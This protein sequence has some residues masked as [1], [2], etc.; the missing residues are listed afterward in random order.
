MKKWLIK[1]FLSFQGKNGIEEIEF[2]KAYISYFYPLEYF[3]P[4]RCCILLNGLVFDESIKIAKRAYFFIKNLNG[5][6]QN[7][8]L[9]SN[10]TK[11]ILKNFLENGYFGEGGTCVPGIFNNCFV[12]WTKLEKN[13]E[14]EFL[15]LENGR[16]KI[17]KVNCDFLTI[18]DE[19]FIAEVP[20][21]ID[22]WS[23]KKALFFT[24][25]WWEKRQF[26][27]GKIQVLNPLHDK[28]VLYTLECLKNKDKELDRIIEQIL[29]NNIIS[30]KNVLDISE[31]LSCKNLL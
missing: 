6:W 16:F 29:H 7:W 24:K 28:I 8:N 11:D 22:P 18:N 20:S 17:S 2:L 19:F 13:R 15:F 9:E 10:V 3:T 30:V 12:L 5:Y 27:C 1:H 14:I 25:Q 4:L 31:I 23:C 21:K 26:L